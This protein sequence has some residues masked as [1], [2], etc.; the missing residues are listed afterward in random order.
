VN[1]L[2]S[3]I[4]AVLL[5]MSRAAA[6]GALVQRTAWGRRAVQRFV[7]GNS[8]DEAVVVAVVMKSRGFTVTLDRLGEASIGAKAD[9]YAA[10]AALLLTAQSAAGLTPNVSVKLTAVGLSEGDAVAAARLDR[11]LVVR[12]F[13]FA[14]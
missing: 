8:I 3:I 5:R 12:A 9:A 4:R 11:I 1:P 14:S 10:D 13:R 2:F 7:A 6:L